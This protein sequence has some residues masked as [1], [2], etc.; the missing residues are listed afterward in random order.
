MIHHLRLYGPKM[1]QVF[2][3]YKQSVKERSA[4]LGVG[5]EWLIGGVSITVVVSF[6][7][8][9]FGMPWYLILLFIAIIIFW[10]KYPYAYMHKAMHLSEFW[11]IKNPYTSKWFLY[12]RDL[13]D[14]H[15]RDVDDV[16]RMNTNYGICFFWLDKFFG[17]YKPEHQKFN[18]KGFVRSEKLYKDIIK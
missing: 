6:I 11:M 10:A 13:H 8:Y 2:K 5:Y 3:K 4:F 1:P 14:I 12:I 17:T 7:L 9:L 18:E 15:H 16:G